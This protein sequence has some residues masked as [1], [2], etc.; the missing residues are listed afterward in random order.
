MS[1]ESDPTVD[2]TDLLV[3]RLLDDADGQFRKRA[4]KAAL[5]GDGAPV[6]QIG[7]YQVERR[8]GQGGMAVVYAARDETLER[9]VALKLLTGSHDAD[10]S[11]E[12]RRLLREATALARLQHRAVATVHE[13]DVHEGHTYLAMEYVDGQT[14]GQ[15]LEERP[16]PYKEILAAFV[17]AGEGLAAAH[18]SEIVHR[19][20]KPANVMVAKDGRIVVLD[21]GL[22]RSARVDAVEDPDALEALLAPPE[23]SSELSYDLTMTGTFLGTP[24]YMSPEQYLGIPATAASDQFS[25]CVALYEAVYGERPFPANSIAELSRAVTLGPRPSPRGNVPRR[26]RRAILRGLAA[27]AEQRWPSMTALLD[28]L[29]RVLRPRRGLALVAGAAIVG[30]ASLGAAAWYADHRDSQFDAQ[31]RE[32]RDAT[33]MQAAASIEDRDPTT[34]LAL[35]REVEDPA[36]TRGWSEAALGLLQR[37]VCQVVQRDHGKAWPWTTVVSPSGDHILTGSRDNSVHLTRMDGTGAPWVMDDVD[38]AA[39][40]MSPD[41]RTIVSAGTVVRAWSFDGHGEPTDPIQFRSTAALLTAGSTPGLVV[42]NDG[43]IVNGSNDGTVYTWRLPSPGHEPGPPDM[44]AAHTKAAW[45]V[46][47]A[48]DGHTMA[49]ASIDGTAKIWSLDSSPPTELATMRHDGPIWSIRYSPDGSQLLTASSDYYAR[50]WSVSTGGPVAEWMHGG[51]LLAAE[52]SPD[53]RL[54]ATGGEQG[55]VQLWSVERPKDDALVLS[56]HEANVND[57]E[58]SP[59]G[60]QLLSTSQDATARVWNISEEGAS[61]SAPVVFQIDEPVFFGR[62]APDGQ[63]VVLSSQNSVTRVCDVARPA[64]STTLELGSSLRSM[65]GSADGSVL[66]GTTAQGIVQLSGTGATT[67]DS[68]KPWTNQLVAITPD[69]AWATSR[70]PSGDVRVWQPSGTRVHRAGTELGNVRS[71]AISADAKWLAVADD[72]G[73]LQVWSFDASELKPRARMS[74]RGAG[75]DALAFTSRGTLVAG[76]RKGRLL[77]WTS[78][79]SAPV[80]LDTGRQALLMVVAAQAKDRLATI[81]DAGTTRLWTIEDDGQLSAIAALDG[82]DSRPRT[83]AFVEGGDA[84][85]AATAEGRVMRWNGPD[86][87]GWQ[88]LGS[89]PVDGELGPMLIVNDGESI[90]AGGISNRRF[91]RWAVEDFQ[92]DSEAL[93]RRLWEATNEC[94][95]TELRMELLDEDEDAAA[96]AVETCKARH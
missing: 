11:T 46:A 78:F 17:E 82:G 61:V 85:L 51:P 86:G 9:T 41:G 21:F 47:L 30:T 53:G 5:L 76:D 18:A 33:R 10:A 14:L 91:H 73:E 55:T 24:A 87:Q 71:I 95:S 38:A 90:V 23:D 65:A 67:L 35:V 45:S 28:E 70:E 56:G 1:A 89:L 42:S 77:H 80:E 31:S 94:L 57:V 8:L 68:G 25:F 63:R 12:R 84:L 16:R 2:A 92:T 93:S 59:D 6:Q 26:L 36:Q 49:T 13:V 7:R 4:I 27:R 34:A 72:R 22:A 58:F 37:P 3:P 50:L 79:D 96:K 88:T 62:F 83:I 60:S 19:D 44:L 66:V 29:R 52:F 74:G 39:A 48:P 64:S 43:F 75:I 54:V 15:W 32:A 81:D 20:F 40:A 69:G